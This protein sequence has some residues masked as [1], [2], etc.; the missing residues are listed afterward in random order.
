MFVIMPIVA[1]ALAMAFELLRSVEIVLVALA[2]SPIP[3]LLP[4]RE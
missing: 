3:P 1:V 4:G 2:I